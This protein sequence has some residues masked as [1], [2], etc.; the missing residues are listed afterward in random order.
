MESTGVTLAKTPSNGVMK[1]KLVIF[2][3]QARPKMEGLGH[4]PNCNIF[5]LQFVLPAECAGTGKIII[6]ETRE[7]SSSN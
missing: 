2:Y 1:L 7:T 5:H 4:Q 6:K 3:Y